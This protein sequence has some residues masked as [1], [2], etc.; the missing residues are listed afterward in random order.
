MIGLHDLPGCIV[1]LQARY[2]CSLNVDMDAITWIGG[3]FSCCIVY[4]LFRKLT[5]AGVMLALVLGAVLW[6][7]TGYAGL[8]LIGTFF[9][10]GVFSTAFQRQQKQKL[11]MTASNNSKRT[12]GQVWA[13]GG[14]ALLLG[15][16]AWFAPEQKVQATLLIACASSAATAD[17]LS[18]ELGMVWGKKTF[19]ILTF[20][21]DKRGENGV[22]SVEGILAGLMGSSIIALVYSLLTQFDVVRF[23]IIVVAGL[24]GT[25]LDSI[26]GATLER[27]QKMGNN[28]VNWLN[29]CTGAAVG[30]LLYLLL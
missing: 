17:T 9:L 13:N 21:P 26:L 2:L 16:F 5:P 8:L 12:A 15:L 30:W 11:E 25:I 24:G 28:T 20:R 27:Q 3:F 14:V 19:N 1:F 7:G 18:S 23:L 29:T 4:L 22:I 10:L 6:W